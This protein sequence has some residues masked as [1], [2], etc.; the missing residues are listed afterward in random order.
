MKIAFARMMHALEETDVDSLLQSFE[1]M[2]SLQSSFK[3]PAPQSEIKEVSKSKKVERERIKEA[4]REDSG[5]NKGQKLR[6]PVDAWP[7]ELIMFGRVTGM[8]RGLCTVLNVQ[9]PYLATMAK[10]ARQT[11]CEE[12][13]LRENIMQ[14]NDLPSNSIKTKLQ[15]KL[16]EVM[17]KC[18]NVDDKLGLQLCVFSKGKV[19]AN[20]ASGVMGKADPRPVT[21]STLFC[22]FSVSKA[23]LSVG[24]LR[25]IEERLIDIDDPIAKHWPAFGKNGKEKVTVKHALTHQSGL[26]H[27]FPEK[28]T[29]D[30]LL[31]WSHMKKVV[32]NAQPRH[33]PGED[34]Q[35][36]ALSF[37]WIVGG[38][39]EAVTG[40]PYEEYLN[41]IME[42]LNLKDMYMA[43]LPKD[44]DG[45]VASL[46]AKLPT[47]KKANIT[48]SS[49]EEEKTQYGL[50]K[51][52]GVEQLM[53]PLVFNMKMV[54]EAKLP[55][56]NGITSA[57][58]LASLFDAVIDTGRKN[59][60]LSS[61]T[62][63]I[64]CT[65]QPSTKQKERINE[66]IEHFKNNRGSLSP[67]KISDM[68][69]A[70]AQKILVKPDSNIDAAGYSTYGIGVKVYDV[71]LRYGKT[72]AVIGHEGFGGSIVFAIPE[73]K[74]S[75][76]FVT[77]LL[78]ISSDT[79]NQL[80]KVVMEEFGVKPRR[81]LK[82]YF[83]EKS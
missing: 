30:T 83:F 60:L 9:Y 6:N 49:S 35:Y 16:V 72:A 1:D 22:I 38:I 26:A 5:L 2:A 68:R 69:E 24:I 79:K 74:L 82:R 48:D 46:S 65:K 12:V 44:F 25:L 27:V 8:L 41:D 81:G 75:V 50:S 13:M 56:A 10:A 47:K 52:R 29:I 23:V 71:V 7:D 57:F 18:E 76:A 58:A 34:T 78:T 54:Q 32:E 39:I 21:P 11:L 73:L 64:A 63:K 70:V 80:L 31:D 17:K 62:L 19:A 66:M 45:R 20:I 53:N 51:H 4:K 40:R 61:A 14:N 59:A 3:D 37:A 43:G 67:E 77:N 42:P 15:R 36:H 33:A 55:S 28:V